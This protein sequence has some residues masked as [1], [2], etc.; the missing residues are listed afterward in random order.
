MGCQPKIK[1]TSNSGGQM[2]QM[3][4][5]PTLK[6]EP[7]VQDDDVVNTLHKV[8]G[9]GVRD[10]TRLTGFVPPRNQPDYSYFSE[11]SGGLRTRWGVRTRSWM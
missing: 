9:L 5:M 1:E 2:T 10:S 8:V 3:Y 7:E 4:F 11:T 6:T